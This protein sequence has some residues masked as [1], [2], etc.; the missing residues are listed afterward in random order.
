[1]LLKSR[2]P[3]EPTNDVDRF[4]K[5]AGVAPTL[6]YFTVAIARLAT[7]AG[8]ETCSVCLDTESRPP[9]RRGFVL[10]AFVCGLPQ[11]VM[12]GHVRHSCAQAWAAEGC[13]RHV[14]ED[15]GLQDRA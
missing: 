8:Q 11:L 2:L 3:E 1:M 10:D 6:Q 12:D 15:A 13:Y 5:R 14:L 9:Q 4:M 7:Y